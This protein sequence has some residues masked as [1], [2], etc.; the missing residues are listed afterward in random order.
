MQRRRFLKSSAAT[1]GLI[2]GQQFCWGAGGS[3]SAALLLEAAQFQTKGGW[4][5]DQQFMDPPA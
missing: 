5:L 1:S 4:V 3:R 2:L